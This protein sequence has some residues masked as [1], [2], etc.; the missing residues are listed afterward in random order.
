[1]PE[2]EDEHQREEPLS[3]KF[4]RHPKVEVAKALTTAAI[5]YNLKT[6]DPRSIR[7]YSTILFAGGRRTGKSFCAR[8]ILFWLKDRIYDAYVYSGTHDEDHPW[9]KFTPPKY[10][11]YVKQDFPNDDLQ[12]AL[13]KQDTRKE[14]AK[15]H[16]IKGDNCPPTLFMFED[17]EFLKKS[18]WKH[19]AIREVCFNGRWKKCF[20][21]AAVQYIMEI[22]MPVRSMFDYAFFTM[23]PVQAVRERIWK[24]YAGIFPTFDE[25]EAAFVQCTANHGCMV[26]DC[27]ATTYKIEDTVF[28]FTAADRGF[29]QLG[30][31]DVWDENVDLRNLR[32]IAD[33]K[34]E[35]D[36]STMPPAVYKKKTKKTLEGGISV[37][38]T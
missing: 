22:D 16:N 4:S 23:C 32:R 31:D 17:L 37:T 8:D 20:A 11:K 2:E 1:M 7:D 14:I 33:E 15:K 24:Q 30:V 9:E 25:F 13:D 5:N 35:Q 12:A 27:R 6:F 29:F 21:L 10:V 36:K 34:K 28:H 18:M 19:Q 38:L 3:R 26:I